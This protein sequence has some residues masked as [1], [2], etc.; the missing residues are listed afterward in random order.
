MEDM[1]KRKFLSSSWPVAIMTVLSVSY[2]HLDK[3][4]IYM[5]RRGERD[6]F[7]LDK[8]NDKAKYDYTSCSIAGLVTDSWIQ[9]TSFIN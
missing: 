4:I 1:G 9:N 8:Q 6:A 7:I 2:H 5:G 3:I